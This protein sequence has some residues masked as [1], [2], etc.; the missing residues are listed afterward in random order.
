MFKL[1][2][3]GMKGKRKANFQLIIII[4]LSFFLVT[5]SVITFSTIEQY[6]VRQKRDIYGTFDTVIQN[7]NKDFIESIKNLDNVENKSISRFIGY[8][9]EFGN[10]QTLDEKSQEMLSIKLVE[11]R[12]PENE[13]EIILDASQT[14]YFSKAPE[15]GEIMNVEIESVI[16]NKL[17]NTESLYNIA[18]QVNL[19]DDEEK[20]YRSLITDEWKNFFVEESKKT[21]EEVEKLI[22]DNLK[23]IFQVSPGLISNERE[24]KSLE[25]IK[26]LTD[27]TIIPMKV[28]NQLINFITEVATEDDFTEFNKNQN[29]TPEEINQ[30]YQKMNKRNEEI[31][32]KALTLKPI[33]IKEF[34]ETKHKVKE[35]VNVY[36]EMKVV[37]YFSN[38]SNLHSFDSRYEPTAFVTEK[39]GN[40][41]IKGLKHGYENLEETFTERNNIYLKSIDNTHEYKLKDA[42]ADD[43]LKFRNLNS[44]PES[45]VS[46]SEVIN[47][48]LLVFIYILTFLSIFQIFLIQFKKRLRSLALFKAIGAKNRQMQLLM[49]YELLI[50][51]LIALPLG[52]I[53]G[54][55]VSKIISEVYAAK[56]KIAPDLIVN[57]RLL[58]P[59]LVLS[60]LSCLTGIILPLGRINKISLTGNISTSNSRV[61]N[62]ERIKNLKVRKHE[63][64]LTYMS[65][66][67]IS[68]RHNSFYK[69][70]NLI[71]ITVYSV[72][73]SALLLSLIISYLAFR[74][75]IEN[76]VLKNKP[77]FT[78]TDK[79]AM[80][81]LSKTI[82]EEFKEIKNIESSEIINFRNG[83]IVKKIKDSSDEHNDEHNNDVIDTITNKE[84]QK[85]DSS[86]N[87]KDPLINQVLKST[88]EKYVEK[89][90]NIDF[91][92]KMKGKSDEEVYES[93]LTL[94]SYPVDGTSM[95][96]IIN[97]IKTGKVD[98]EKFKEGK[99]IIILAPL[100]RL[101]GENSKV[102]TDELTSVK[103]DYL[104]SFLFKSNKQNRISYDKSKVKLLERNNVYEDLVGKIVKLSFKDLVIGLDQLSY[105]VKSSDVEV[106]SIADN[107]SEGIWPLSDS[108]DFPV[109]ICSPDL[110]WQNVMKMDF[111]QVNKE[112]K[113]RELD[114]LGK[115]QINVYLKDKEDLD[116]KLKIRKI[117]N[118]H[119]LEVN[120][121]TSE[122]RKIYNNAFKIAVA[123][124]MFA[125]AFVIIALQIQY[126]SVKSR[127]NE[128]RSFIGILQSLGLTHGEIKSMY[129]KNTIR[130]LAFSIVIS[131]ISAIAVL[132]FQALFKYGGEPSFKN[133]ILFYV[134]NEMEMYPYLIHLSV[135]AVLF[136]IVIII[137]Y[138]PIRKMSQVE[139]VNNIRGLN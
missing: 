118:E 60:V 104:K 122:N 128:E 12:M 90:F 58:I 63:T 2:F 55:A 138:L 105:E 20:Y 78:I 44:Y 27:T 50:L 121:L 38:I 135:I 106:A 81:R 32:D 92:A 115:S 107:L 64:D 26:V 137:S 85:L 17:N 18:A 30:F 111:N 15:V 29:R 132:I 75:Y 54:F 82:N 3:K 10:V 66:S 73:A 87:I 62:L 6:K 72:M 136:I 40:I 88:P 100:Y 48:C 84:D 77:D 74:P 102:T 46:T 52:L 70:Q 14:P 80:V 83:A 61:K 13:N 97:S 117:A 123:S 127:L 139:P 119:F 21:P 130:Q 43:S 11:G 125:L 59:G 35:S 39:G 67:D 16:F 101:E 19:T 49:F 116:T 114:L 31:L 103:R 23:R 57:L 47:K 76:V 51:I 65:V 24:N 53:L 42:I 33:E 36:R 9:K 124:V 8:S 68:K 69:K 5:T 134:K 110:I 37:G 120:D 1:A 79:A 89:L 41:F 22:G 126:N 71:S 131:H 93:K 129:L 109:I 28:N 94:M 34:T 98:I 45:G 113:E 86:L 25:D 99:Q 7:Q 91:N 56:Y 96:T 95:K 108:I 112:I 4:F 133:N